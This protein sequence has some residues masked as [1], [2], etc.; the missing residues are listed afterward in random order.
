MNM[1]YQKYNNNN[2]N[3]YNNNCDNRNT[4]IDTAIPV[5]RP[6][7]SRAATIPA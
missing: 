2:I 3:N 7:T 6:I 1:I 5:A 4:F